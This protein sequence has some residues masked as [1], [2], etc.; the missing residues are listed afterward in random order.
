MN[1]DKLINDTKA[2]LIDW[3][4]FKLIVDNDSGHIECID[5]SLSDDERLEK[6]Y[7]MQGKYGK[8]D[9]YRDVVD[10][11]LACG[12]NAAWR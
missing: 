5:E 11:L 4:K 10:I 1:Y 12:V 8:P 7:E 3:S 6:R 2:G 9:G